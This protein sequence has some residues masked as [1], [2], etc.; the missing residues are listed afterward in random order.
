MTTSGRGVGV[1]AWRLGA[2]ARRVVLVAH[3][4][5][6]GAWLGLD[7]AL[8][9]LVI[10][11]LSPADAVGAAAALTSVGLVAAWPLAAAGLVCLATGVLLGLGSKHGLV[12]S[13]WTAVKLV[14]NLVLVVLVVGV[15]LPEVQDVAAQAR[16]AL[17]TGAAPAPVGDLVYPPLVSCAALLAATVLAV[18]KPWGRIRRRTAR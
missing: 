15:L 6:A 3:V 1:A 18:V 12:R 7:L 10:A 17:S 13:W 4:T 11:A 9:L 14:I 5:A 16:R 2:R 8:G